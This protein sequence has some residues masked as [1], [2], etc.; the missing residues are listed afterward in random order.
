METEILKL[1]HNSTTVEPTY[2]GTSVIEYHLITTCEGLKNE[3]EVTAEVRGIPTAEPYLSVWGVKALT[4]NE[5]TLTS[6]AVVDL[7]NW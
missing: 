4:N 6:E 1:E 2:G 3:Y 5:N 7:L